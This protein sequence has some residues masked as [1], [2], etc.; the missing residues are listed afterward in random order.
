MKDFKVVVPFVEG[1]VQIRADAAEGALGLIK[2][3]NDHGRCKAEDAV[4]HTMNNK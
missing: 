4:L 2:Q 3:R 1:R